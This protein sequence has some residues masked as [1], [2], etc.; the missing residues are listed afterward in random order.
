MGYWNY[1]LVKYADGSGFGLHEVYY[2]DDGNPDA[3]TQ[4]P[5]GFQCDLEEGAE[6]ISE[7]LAQALEDAVRK[8][9]FDEPEHWGK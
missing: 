1:R 7:M 3:M 4:D 9:V 5:I 2:D 6:T 8:P